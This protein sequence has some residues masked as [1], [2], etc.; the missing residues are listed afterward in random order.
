MKIL[1]TGASGYIGSYLVR[2]FSN[3]KIEFGAI[4]RRKPDFLSEFFQQTPIYIT[5]LESLPGL[6]IHEHYD[7]LIH[8]ASA[9]DVD[10]KD[11]LSALLTTGYGT[12]RI[13]EFCQRN[14]IPRMIYFSTFQVYGTNEGMVSEETPVNCR[15][16]YALTHLIGE[17]Y[18]RIARQRGEL[19]GII[20]RPTNIYGAP[21]HKSVDRWSLVPTCFCKEAVEQGRITLQSSG[22][23]V[24]DFISLEDISQLT[25][26]LAQNFESHRNQTVNLASGH[27]R[28]ILET[29]ALTTR[30]YREMTGKN[31][32]VQTLTSEPEN[33]A[34]LNVNT[35]K[36][37]NLPY[38]CRD[39]MEEEIR[40]IFIFLGL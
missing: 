15:N 35:G 3:Q 1:L 7:V 36:L 10:S 27:V 19:D 31:I 20:L 8:L 13:I 33:S 2:Y 4:S 37:E 5:D 39:T 25:Q 32:E 9:N 30:V 21:I 16:D 18:V 24:R 12:R 6:T 11:P 29:A 14:Y 23:Q 38:I 22:K 26:I 34:T 28:T 17:E 40:K